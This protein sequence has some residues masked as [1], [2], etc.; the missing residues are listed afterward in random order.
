MVS[1]INIKKFCIFAKFLIYMKIHG[2]IF[3]VIIL[4][5]IINFYIFYSFQKTVPLQIVKTILLILQISGFLMFISTFLFSNYLNYNVTAFFY[6]IGTTYFF[7]MLYMLIIC[8][9]VDCIRIFPFHFKKYF[10]NNWIV[11]FT[12]ILFITSLFTIGYINYKHKKRIEFTIESNKNIN[13]GNLKIVAIS[14][15][16]LGF[17]INKN[18]FSKWIDL[19]NK[20]EADIVIIAGDI[21]DNSLK[22]L[23][24]QNF[25]EL[26]YK[27]KTK[28]GIFA[29]PG[30]HEYH[31]GIEKTVNFFK[32]T[33]ICYLKDSVLLVNNNFY[34]IGRDDKSN[35][36]RKTIKELCQEIDSS[37]FTI[38]I[39]HQPINL[40]ESEQNNINFQFS[41]HTHD[42][43]LYP[44]K[45]FTNLMYEKSHGYIKKSNTNYFISSGIGIWGGKY[46]IGSSSEYVVINVKGIKK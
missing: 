11:F 40:K 41:G 23:I 33:N 24:E 25:A 26:F 9:L 17:N 15:L 8:V 1:S 46:R 37:K 7:V 43:Q 34:I 16:H 22:P 13:N 28:Y 30:N 10:Y 38:L 2:F 44:I 14:D 19:I 42:G 39:D 12:I 18:E 45:W 32:K 31:A 29:V 27:I 36:E 6:K 3:I 35:N 21:I 4:F 20:E 5:I